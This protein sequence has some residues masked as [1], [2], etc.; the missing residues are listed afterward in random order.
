MRKKGLLQREV[1]VK[2]ISAVSTQASTIAGNIDTIII[3][4]CF[5]CIA[6]C[7]FTTH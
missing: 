3:D 6:T 7:A 4:W 5:A 1:T 2:G